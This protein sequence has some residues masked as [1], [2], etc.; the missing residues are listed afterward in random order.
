MKSAVPY[1][2]LVIEPGT[3]EE[4]PF[5]TLTIS[6]GIVNAYEAVKIAQNMIKLSAR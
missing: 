5:E 3:E 1:D 6:G 4:V 2:G